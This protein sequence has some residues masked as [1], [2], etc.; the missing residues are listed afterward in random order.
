[1]VAPSK[2]F[3][4]IP[5]ADIDP[6]SPITTGLM[7]NFR[8]NDI[9]LEEWL[10][11]GFVAAKNHNHDGVNSAIIAGASVPVK[12]IESVDISSTVTDVDFSA[13]LNGD[14]DEQW[15]LTGRF[16]TGTAAE[17]QLRVN[18]VNQTGTV[19]G[20]AAQPII[21]V[22]RQAAN[23]TSG[24][25]FAW[26]KVKSDGASSSK[27]IRHVV[28]LSSVREAGASGGFGGLEGNFTPGLGTNITKIGFHSTVASGIIDGCFFSIYKITR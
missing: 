5:D 12:F 19:E 9:H 1:M 20:T 23:I 18:S 27:D 26:L 14:T 6:D 13:V 11:D 15:I 16:T 8:D 10:G 22:E 3:T 28:S 2:S 25:F 7:T 24:F 17:L 21:L 4:V